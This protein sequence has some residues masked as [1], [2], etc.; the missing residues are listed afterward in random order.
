MEI[1]YERTM[2]LPES[3]L[4]MVSRSISFTLYRASSAGGGGGLRSSSLLP[5]KVLRILETMFKMRRVMRDTKPS[6]SGSSSTTVPSDRVTV[7]RDSTV[8][9]RFKILKV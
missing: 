9:N 6:F 8:E 7:R 2:L 5:V 1:V 4:F 3:F